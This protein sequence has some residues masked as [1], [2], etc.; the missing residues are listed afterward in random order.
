MTTTDLL[1]LA[2]ETMAALAEH[3]NPA[4]Q[5][6][7]DDVGLL[8]PDWGPVF[9]ALGAD[10][11]PVTS[12]YLVE[13]LEADPKVSIL[14]NAEVASVETDGVKMRSVT[15]KDGR[16]LPAKAIGLFLGANPAADWT[17]A[18]RDE[19]GFLKVGGE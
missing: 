19:K 2:L 16:V 11:Q 4:M 18:E 8:P 1:P 3:Y 12:A 15:L 10:P 14:E 17:G 6:V 7:R 13:Q 5:Q 9:T